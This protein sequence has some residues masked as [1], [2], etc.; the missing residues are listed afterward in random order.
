MKF[1][2]ETHI[3]DLN[4]HDWQRLA[5]IVSPDGDQDLFFQLDGQY[6]IASFLP[7]GRCCNASGHRYFREGYEAFLEMIRLMSEDTGWDVNVEWFIDP[8]EVIEAERGNHSLQDLL[9]LLQ[10]VVEPPVEVVVD[11]NWQDEGF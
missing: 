1:T 11:Y 8:E 6:I 7:N 3:R 4:L 9:D 10:S 2:A 5:R